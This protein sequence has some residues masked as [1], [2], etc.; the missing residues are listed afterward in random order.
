[1]TSTRPGHKGGE[2][3]PEI[4]PSRVTFYNKRDDLKLRVERVEKR[5]TDLGTFVQAVVKEMRQHAENKTESLLGLACL[6][7]GAPVVFDFYCE[8]HQPPKIRAIWEK[9]KTREAKR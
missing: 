1:M 7:C 8:P 5:L 3:V 4:H 2:K 6:K 9:I